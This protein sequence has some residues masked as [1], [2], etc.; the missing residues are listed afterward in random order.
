MSEGTGQDASLRLLSG[1]FENFLCGACLI[2]PP[3]GLPRDGWL[4][5]L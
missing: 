3:D 2:N 4:L 1:R 5:T